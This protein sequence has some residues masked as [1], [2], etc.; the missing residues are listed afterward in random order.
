MSTCAETFFQWP[1]NQYWFSKCGRDQI[2]SYWSSLSDLFD[3]VLVG[4]N[5]IKGH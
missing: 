4:G 1:E 3:F 5:V 2:T